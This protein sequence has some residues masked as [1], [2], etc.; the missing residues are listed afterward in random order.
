M[1]QSSQS[2]PTVREIQ[3]HSHALVKLL[4]LFTDSMY[5]SAFATMVERAV[6]EE[7]SH[8]S[9]TTHQL[10]LLLVI[11]SRNVLTNKSTIE[12]LIPLNYIG[13]TIH[14]SLLQRGSNSKWCTY[15]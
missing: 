3:P 10:L 15:E 5:L 7:L 13:V 2:A 11:Q 1:N 8:S 12:V 14:H 9:P 4:P 6:V